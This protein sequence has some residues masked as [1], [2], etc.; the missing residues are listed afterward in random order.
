MSKSCQTPHP[1]ILK[2]ATSVSIEKARKPSAFYAVYFLK[3]KPHITQKTAFMVC[4]KILL[5]LLF[6]ISCICYLF[7]VISR[8]SDVLKMKAIIAARP[9]TVAVIFANSYIRTVRQEP[10][11]RL[12]LS[13][14][15]TAGLQ[16]YLGQVRR[17]ISFAA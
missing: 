5:T 3:T 12:I 1:L 4:V 17:N 9:A 10:C 11:L 14:N 15:G 16:K 13:D 7:T 8:H 2:M 6:I